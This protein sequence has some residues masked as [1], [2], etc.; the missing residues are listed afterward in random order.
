MI[1]PIW[2]ASWELGCCQPEAE[3][4][5]S[6][7][8][9]LRFTLG[10]T[11]WRATEFGIPLS[12]EQMS[13]GRVEVDLVPLPAKR[14]MFEPI[15]QLSVISATSTMARHEIDELPVG[16]FHVSSD[17]IVWTDFPTASPD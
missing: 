3:V 8:V 7:A 2:V 13:F 16:D 1:L 5:Q 14:Q 4:G 9:P 12:P 17:L 11:P 15:E 6:W 10:L